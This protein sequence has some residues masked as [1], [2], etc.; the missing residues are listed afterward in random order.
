V[1]AYFLTL[2]YW[3]AGSEDNVGHMVHYLV[4]RY[5]D[6]SRRALRGVARTHE[7]VDYPELGV[8]HPRLPQRLSEHAADLPR[9]ATSGSAAR[10]DCC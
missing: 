5:A 7:P 3:L 9:V 8:Y 10:S 6:G 2:Q 4:D 1:R